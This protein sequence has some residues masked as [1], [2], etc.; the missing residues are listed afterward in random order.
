MQQKAVRPCQRKGSKPLMRHDLKVERKTL[1]K[2]KDLGYFSGR[3][4]LKDVRKM[5]RWIN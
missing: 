4:K 5:I 1:P 3:W 2:S